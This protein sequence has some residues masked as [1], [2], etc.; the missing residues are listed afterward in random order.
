MEQNTDNLRARNDALQAQ[1]DGMLEDLDR[2]SQSLSAAQA[3][4]SRLRVTGESADKL[5]RVQV[6]SVGAVVDVDISQSALRNGDVSA[7]NRAVAEAARNAAASA[8]EQVTQTMSTVI[9]MPGQ[10][11]DLPDLV[12]GSPSLR[13]IF[14]SVDP[15]KAASTEPPKPASS[16]DDDDDDDFGWGQSLLEDPR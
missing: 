13:Q 3:E 15:R 4:V 16:H 7:L 10:M 2:Q 11:P 6:D 14:D 9:G 1:I 8:R 5:A 12:P